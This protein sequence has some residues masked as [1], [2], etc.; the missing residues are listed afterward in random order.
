MLACVQAQFKGSSREIE[1]QVKQHETHASNKLRKVKA[2][3]KNSVV[4]FKKF[5]TVYCFFPV[6][7]KKVIKL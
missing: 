6:N 4:S 1:Q 3:H 7:T 5:C 2:P